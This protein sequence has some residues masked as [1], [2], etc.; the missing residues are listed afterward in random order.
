MWSNPQETADLVTLLEEILNG[1][2]LFLCSDK[3]GGLFFLFLLKGCYYTE[4]C[5][6]NV[7]EH[8][9][10]LLN[11]RL[12]HRCFPVNFTIFLRTPFLKNNSRRL[13]LN[14]LQFCSAGIFYFWP[15]IAGLRAVRIFPVNFPKFFRTPFLIEHLRRLLLVLLHKFNPLM[16]GGNKSS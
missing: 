5:M 10:T 13:L 16:S 2:L 11:K 4:A 6:C 7:K 1:K 8:P 15:F 12:W 14:S 9:A 3:R